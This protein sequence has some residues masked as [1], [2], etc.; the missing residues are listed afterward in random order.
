MVTVPG[1]GY[2]NLESCMATA[3]WKSEDFGWG[4]DPHLA[5]KAP[6][7][8]WP[9]FLEDE[10]GEFDRRCASSEGTRVKLSSAY[11]SR[12]ARPLPTKV[13]AACKVAINCTGTD[14]EGASQHLSLAHQQVSLV[15]VRHFGFASTP[16]PAPTLHSLGL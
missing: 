8:S 5:R 3:L 14:G 13:K 7:G 4:V 16:V 11:V 12:Y 15:A 6:A 9:C 2:G 1:R 10:Q